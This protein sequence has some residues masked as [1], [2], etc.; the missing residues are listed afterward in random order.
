M[1]EAARK[2]AT[3][4]GLEERCSFESRALPL[5]PFTHL[6]KLNP[7]KLAVLDANKLHPVPTQYKRAFTK[8]FSNA[9]LHWILR[10]EETREAVFRGVRDSLVDNGTFAFEMGGLGNVA[11][12]RAALLGAVARRVGIEKAREA[13]PWFFPDE[14]WYVPPKHSCNACSWRAN[15]AQDYGYA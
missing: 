5:S 14:K 7:V 12:M 2:K 9:A 10:S 1:I 8:A 6:L 15:E 11:E 3:E 13:D 4:A